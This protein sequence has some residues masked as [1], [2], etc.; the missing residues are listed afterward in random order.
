MKL[1]AA[2][3]RMVVECGAAIS[4]E[5]VIHS[6][7]RIAVVADQDGRQIELIQTQT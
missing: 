6:G 2:L 7:H 5:P 3:E 1:D 4:L